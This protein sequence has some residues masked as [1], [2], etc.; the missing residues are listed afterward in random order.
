MGVILF[1]T[2]GVILFVGY[3]MYGWLIVA[4][5]FSLVL[6]LATVIGVFIIALKIGYNL[7]ILYHPHLRIKSKLK[8]ITDNI[9]KKIGTLTFKEVK[10][11]VG[12]FF[13]LFA[14]NISL[15]STPLPMPEIVPANI[16][17]NEFLFDFHVHTTMSDG[18]LTPEQ[19]VLWYL[20]HGI[21]GAAFSDHHNTRGGLAAREF[22]E[23]Y[24]LD[25]T[26]IVAQEYTDDPEQIHLNVFGIEE[27]ITPKDYTAGPYAPNEMNCEETIKWVKNNGGY[28]FVNHYVW[29]PGAPF[30]YEQLR[31]WGVDG[32]EIINGGDYD[33]GYP[34]VRDF[35]I[36]NNLTCLAGSDIHLNRELNT[37]VRFRLDDPTNLTLDNIFNTLRKN[38]HQCV[39]IP[40]RAYYENFHPMGDF[41]EIPEFLD[42][43]F[44]LDT[45]Q[46]ISWMVWSMIVYLSMVLIIRRVQHAS[47]GKLRYKIQVVSR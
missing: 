33:G 34:G 29:V 12:T 3:L 38:E 17:E 15:L 37:F 8:H 30:T 39:A 31:D 11:F 1:A 32:F 27:D 46:S 14:I 18:H 10:L 43:I 6:H 24:N 13:I 42:Y 2:F 41:D 16:D 35:C 22:V 4:N 26:V 47:L 19:R 9:G 45:F 21:H 28:V 7:Y 5:S 36:A 25:F 44:T 23:K 20:D 40:E